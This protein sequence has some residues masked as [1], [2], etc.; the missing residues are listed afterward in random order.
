MKKLL[1][2]LSILTI[3]GTAVPTVMAASPYQR[4]ESRNKRQTKQ[5]Q[6]WPSRIHLLDF[7]H[8]LLKNCKYL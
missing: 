3:S 7:L 8:Y 4:Q 5:P 2:L 1:S 6:P